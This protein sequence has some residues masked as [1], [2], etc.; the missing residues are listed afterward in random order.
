MT[1]C[2]NAGGANTEN[3]AATVKS[4]R[5][6]LNMGVPAVIGGLNIPLQGRSPTIQV[7][8]LS[9]TCDRP[10]AN[11]FTTLGRS[12]AMRRRLLRCAGFAAATALTVGA[13]IAAQTDRASRFM[14]NCRR[15]NWNSTGQLCDARDFTISGLRAL[16]VDGRANGGISVYGWDRSDIKVV[17]LV[18]AQAESDAEA[19]DI[20]RQISI[21][22][23][24]GD[25]RAVGPT[26]DRNHESWSV[27][28]EI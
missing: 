10:P 19:S 21:S 4:E 24:N 28:Y 15:N 5:K 18:Q 7:H 6:C 2:D 1:A 3:P 8:A 17:A 14:D 16:V 23:N 11:R 25:I 26:R 22:T 20:A 13:P 9:H 12:S 27:S